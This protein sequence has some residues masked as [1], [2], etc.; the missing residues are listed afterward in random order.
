MA[1][2]DGDPFLRRLFVAALLGTAIVVGIGTLYPAEVKITLHE[3][4]QWLFSTLPI[5]ALVGWGLLTGA[6]VIILG[7]AIM[8]VTKLRRRR[9]SVKVPSA[10]NRRAR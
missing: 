4:G 2:R 3:F 1:T 10:D 9:D 5:G 7:F 6:A 8:L